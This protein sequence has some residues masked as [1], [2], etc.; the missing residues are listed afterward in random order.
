MIFHRVCA[1]SFCI[2]FLSIAG[3]KG[4]HK[5][6]GFR[7]RRL[8]LLQRQKSE[9]YNSRVGRAASLCRLR[10]GG[11]GVSVSLRVSASAHA[12]SCEILGPSSSFK[13]SSEAPSGLSLTL[14]LT[15]PPSPFP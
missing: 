13:T 15:L 7:Q 3:V 12:C 10:G 4:S 2:C 5:C 1:F 11:G 14:T 9:V 8:M 6:G